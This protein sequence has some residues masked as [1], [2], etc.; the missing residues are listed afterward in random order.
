MQ[1]IKNHN[2]E[3]LFHSSHVSFSSLLTTLYTQ[4]FTTRCARVFHRAWRNSISLFEDETQELNLFTTHA[5]LFIKILFD[6][7]GH[8]G[9][10][11]IDQ[12]KKRQLLLSIQSICCPLHIW[13]GTNLNR[14]N[15]TLGI[16]IRRFQVILTPSSGQKW[17]KTLFFRVLLNRKSPRHLGD[18]SWK[19]KMFVYD[20]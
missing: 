10:A 2:Q 5:G 18:G 19:Q 6:D 13:L 1:S 9:A 12:R 11:T 7:G 20:I 8:S 17:Q 3:W 15:L 4:S 14:G 16:R